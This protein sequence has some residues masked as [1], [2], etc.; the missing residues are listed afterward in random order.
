MWPAVNTRKGQVDPLRDLRIIEILCQQG[1]EHCFITQWSFGQEGEMEYKLK[2]PCGIAINSRRQYIIADYGNSS[3]KVFDMSGQFMDHFSVPIDD[4]DHDLVRRKLHDVA[5]D[6][7]DDL[8][9]LVEFCK[10]TVGGS[11]LFVFK[12]NYS[13]ELLHQFSVKVRLPS[14]LSFRSYGVT[15]DINDHV[16]CRSRDVVD[17]YKNDGRF[18]RSFGE[19]L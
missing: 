9:V 5:S 19:G 3:I 2:Y 17:V 7:K 11:E 16:M 15:V 14:K 12:F 6:K 13:G 8:Y 4:V 1:M 18:V 10:P